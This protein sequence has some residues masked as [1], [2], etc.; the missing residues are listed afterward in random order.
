MRIVGQLDETAT[1]Q[2][3]LALLHTSI[4]RHRDRR[5]ASRG[6][7]AHFWQISVNRSLDDGQV[8]GKILPLGRVRTVL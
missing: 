2:G 1:D 5:S 6:S 3:Q 4:S 7:A 8:L